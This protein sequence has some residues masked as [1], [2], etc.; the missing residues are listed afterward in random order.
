MRHCAITQ[1]HHAAC[2][3]RPRRPLPHAATPPRPPPP[4]QS[5]F[6]S[7]PFTFAPPSSSHCIPPVTARRHATRQV[8]QV[9]AAAC[10]DLA[11]MQPANC[12]S[13]CC[14]PPCF[15]SRV[16]CPRQVWP[17][18]SSR[19]IVSNTRI[20]SPRH[21]AQCGGVCVAMPCIV[22]PAAGAKRHA[23]IFAFRK[24]R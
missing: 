20:A 18:R 14:Q 1:R 24:R 15:I 4:P 3:L 13:P 6:T 23:S 19:A 12:C 2:C 7:S 8:H 22:K 21:A 5:P 10:S 11:V 16:L 17:V 9:Q